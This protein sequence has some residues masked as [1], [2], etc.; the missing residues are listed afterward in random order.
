MQ[1]HKILTLITII[2]FT[3]TLT[4]SAFGAAY[5]KL[6]DIKGESTTQAEEQ[7]TGMLLPAIQKA[8]AT[9]PTGDEVA[10]KNDRK[11]KKKGNVDAKWKVEEG[12]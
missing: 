9:A 10:P 4:P 5:L 8:R 1:A 2:L 3:L 12:E 11:S 7:P 6:G